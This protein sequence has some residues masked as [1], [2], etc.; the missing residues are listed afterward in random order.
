MSSQAKV[1]PVRFSLSADSGIFQSW[2]LGRL[3]S[4]EL[5]SRALFF[6][7]LLIVVMISV[8]SFMNAVRFLNRPFP[9]FLVTPRL[10]IANV[11]QPTWTGLQAGLKYPDKVIR[12]NGKRVTSIA[13]FTK[14]VK[15]QKPGTL[16]LYVIERQGTFFTA[17]VSMMWF[18]WLDLSTTFGLEFLSGLAY[19]VIGIVVFILKPDTVV[20]WSF[21]LLCSFLALYNITDFDKG[22]TGFAI[23]Y[24]FAMT[25][26]PAAGLHLSFLFPERNKIIDKFFLLHYVPYLVSAA[27]FIPL[28][29]LYPQPAFRLLYQL[30]LFYLLLAAGGLLVSTIRSYVKGSS[31]LARQRAK[32]I[33][34]GAA[35][36]FPV[37][38]FIH[39]VSFFGESGA[40]LAVLSSFLPVPII[41]FPLSIAY[42]IARHNLFDVDVYIKRAVGYAIM[43]AVVGFGYFSIQTIITKFI[44]EPLFGDYADEAFPIAFALLVVFLFDPINRKIQGTVDRLFFRAK[45]DYKETV[46]SL[47]NALTS[48]LNL[49]QILETVVQ[50]L[51]REM[52]IDAVGLFV[53][54][55][56]SVFC[57]NYY[58]Y[59][60]PIGSEGS[61]RD[62]NLRSDDSLIDLLSQEK[63]LITK[64]DIA[65]DPRYAVIR[66]LCAENFARVDA[67]LAVPLIYQ[68]EL[69]GVLALGH[70]KSGH[71]FTREDIDLLHT[72]S[73]ETAIA[74]ENARRAE[75][76]K[77]EET[78][79]TNLARYLSPQIVDRIV[80]NDVQVNL[81]GDKKVVTVLFSDIRNF[82]T[83]TESRK[84]DELV[85]QLNEYFTEMAAIIFEHG[86]SLDKY[87]G[88]AIVAVFGSLIDLDNSALSA[89]Q[90]A[91]K[92][93]QRLPA[94]NEH[95]LQKYG[96]KMEFGIGLST[97]EVFLGNIGSP[98]RMEFTVIGDTVNVASRFSG[99]AKP[100]QILLTQEVR[101]RLPSNMKVNELPRTTVKGKTGML[102]VFELVLD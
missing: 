69:K 84:P 21:F 56:Q 49:D 60:T 62:P 100:G 16:M 19:V 81:G 78:V 5:G 75:Q 4:T 32:V 67:S 9:G 6:G 96:L 44:F 34:S 98:E 73:D 82:T 58:D 43:T 90:A 79:R 17:A 59:D 2:S 48:L 88:D 42:A 36:A 29:S 52:F 61:P 22:S 15:D 8:S 64:Y 76:M 12:V 63:K 95:W 33:F 39:Y 92:M 45:L 26:I 80:K 11:G 1:Q 55:P 31:V 102:D 65:E 28:A 91:R 30:S 51:R 41:A 101:S 25:F 99:L 40:N 86:G 74:I 83:I 47:S 7:I 68:D 97:G 13:D 38:A 37:P 94:L 72:L 46:Q 57:R 27:L 10:V 85:H 18:S 14:A 87:I 20:S 53:L 35:V 71:F 93:M 77:K 50:T 89:A 54:Q 3:S 70:K 23:I 24:M 66:E